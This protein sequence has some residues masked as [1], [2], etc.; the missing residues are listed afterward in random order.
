MPTSAALFPGDLASDFPSSQFGSVGWRL[1]RAAYSCEPVEEPV[2]V[3]D[4]PR[5][6]AYD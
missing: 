3:W 2:A 6:G 4:G 5:F 1:E